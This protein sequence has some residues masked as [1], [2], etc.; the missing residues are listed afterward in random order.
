[1]IKDL[2][3]GID[4]VHIGLVRYSSTDRIR[5]DLSLSDDNSYNLSKISQ[6]IDE[7]LLFER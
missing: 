5:E 1:M 4:S 3:I 6:I 7:D 2:T